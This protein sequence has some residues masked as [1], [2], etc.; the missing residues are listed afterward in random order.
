MMRRPATTACLV[1]VCAAWACANAPSPPTASAP[2]GRGAVSTLRDEARRHFSAVRAPAGDLDARASL[3]RALFFE[4]VTTSDGKIGCVSCHRPEA[5]GADHVA[6]PTGV[7]GRKSKR[8]APTVFNVAA[9]IAQNWDGARASL[10]E[11]A[12]RSLTAP[13]S[14]GNE[15]FDEPKKRLEA[16]GYRARFEAA[17]PGEPD[18]IT[19][20]SFA[21]AVAAFERLLVT[22]S[23]FD[24]FLE[25]QDDA[26][27]PREQRGLATF[28]EIGCVRCHDHANLG[29]E[30]YERF[31]SSSTDEGRFLVTKV[32]SDRSRFKVP[33]L[34][35]VAE[36]A[37]YF[38]DGSTTDLPTA[39]RTMGHVQLGV[40]LEATRVEDIE[41]F[42]RSLT[43][44]PPAIFSPPSPTAP[45]TSPAAA[46]GSWRFDSDKPNAPP[47]GFSFGRT[48]G[49][50]EGRFVVVAAAD[51]PSKP[52]VLAQVEADP[53]DYRF[54]VAV[55]EGASFKDVA[56]SVSCKPISGKVDQGC[57]LVWRY[58]DANNYYLTRA[59]ALEDN[60]RLYHVKDGQRRQ[61]ASWSGKVATNVWHKLRVEAKGDRFTVYFDDKK[62]MEEKDATFTEPG[63]V[64]V[65]TK[66]DSVIQFDDLSATPL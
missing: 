37:P 47:A 27:S 60:V 38:H 8:N 25:G 12:T 52:N 41:A 10:E 44:T 14:G 58:K 48:G 33:I 49:G 43:G 65:W 61:L 19:E 16:K 40:D 21:S 59:N 42:L 50:N 46:P 53:T 66:A 20:K 3:G 5:W 56:L 22:P 51:A 7:L 36:T 63:R 45:A 54:P 64:G 55:V 35:N 15:S 9:Q 6:I 1:I 39:I 26:L 17:F 29:G 57:G 34:R 11:Q 28:M 2:A 32:D 30:R 31:S 24:A 62:V 4:T 23:R 18:P 13:V